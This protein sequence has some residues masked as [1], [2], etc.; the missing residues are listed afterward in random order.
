LQIPLSLAPFGSLILT[1]ILIPQASFIGHLSGIIVGY[2]ISWDLFWW[3]D[4]TLFYTCFVWT[5][6]GFLY[7]IKT[8]SNFNINFIQME[9]TIRILDGS[10]ELGRLPN[11]VEDV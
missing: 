3:F 4:N 2:L 11:F 7:S 9:S 6:I 5:L 10:I 8:N 1:Q